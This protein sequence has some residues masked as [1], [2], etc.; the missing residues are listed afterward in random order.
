[1]PK[2]IILY[3]LRDDVK[4][5][6]YIEWANKFK[7][8]L[9]MGL[10]STKSYTLLRIRTLTFNETRLADAATDDVILVA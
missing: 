2:Q 6:D 5:E 9:L 1:M 10:P 7:G 4:E 8:P 3:N